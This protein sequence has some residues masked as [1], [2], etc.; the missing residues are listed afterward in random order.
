M[1]ATQE[2]LDE[3]RPKLCPH[4]G[5]TMCTSLQILE[6]FLPLQLSPEHHSIGYQLWFDEFM[7]MWKVCH[8][9]PQWENNMMCLI[10]RLA[11]FNIGYIDWEAYIPFMFTRFIRCLNLPVT[12]K[13]TP[14]NLNHKIE[15]SSITMWIVAT[16]VRYYMYNCG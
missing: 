4:D 10:A 12:Y 11:A 5:L 1:S 14:N 7:T 2:I 8:N 3:L 9:G 6:C 13:Q 16:L 15:M